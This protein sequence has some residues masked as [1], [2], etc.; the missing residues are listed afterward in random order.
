M[1]TTEIMTGMLRKSGRS[2]AGG[3]PLTEPLRKDGRDSRGQEEEEEEEECVSVCAGL[4]RAVCVGLEKGVCECVCWVREGCVCW[5]R[6][7]CV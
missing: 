7:R 6:E 2:K 3:P 1:A 4:E 5:V